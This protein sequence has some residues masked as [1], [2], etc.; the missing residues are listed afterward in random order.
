MEGGT[1][2]SNVS[3]KPTEER[4]TVPPFTC[5]ENVVRPTKSTDYDNFLALGAK[6]SIVID[7]GSHKCRAGWSTEVTPRLEFRSV[8]SKPRVK[9]A[10]ETASIVGEYDLSGGRGFDFSRSSM[11]SAFDGNVV[12]H[13]DT[14]EAIFDYIFERLGITQ[15]SVLHPVL[16][17]ECPLNPSLARAKITEMLIETYGV[18]AVAFGMDCVM[19]YTYNQAQG[20]CGPDGLLVSVGHSATHIIPMLDG[21]PQ[22][23][24]CCRLSVGGYE[25]SDF[26]LRVLR[27]RYPEHGAFFGPGIGFMRAE[28]MKEKFCFVADDYCEMLEKCTGQFRSGD[29]EGSR[30]MQLPFNPAALM[31]AAGPTEEELAR[32]KELKEKQGHRLK[33][34]AAARRESKIAERKAW[35]QKA[36]AL[37]EAEPTMSVQ[38]F[39]AGIR[40]LGFERKELLLVELTAVRQAL[41]KSK[42]SKGGDKEERKEKHEAEPVGDLLD[43]PDAQLSEDQLREKKRQRMM[44]NMW[45][46]RERARHKRE[47]ERARKA[48]EKLEEEE[49]MRVDPEGYLELLKQKLATLS[50]KVNARRKKQLGASSQGADPAG[51]LVG[52]LAGATGSGAALTSKAGRGERLG[53]AQKERMRLLATAA[54]SDNKKEDTFGANDE[55]WE[56]YKEMGNDSDS[57][58]A[59]EDE[60]ALDKVTQTLAEKCPDFVASFQA[61][62]PLLPS[63]APAAPVPV[64]PITEKDFQV[65]GAHLQVYRMA[66]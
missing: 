42:S 41:K 61:S 5:W 14:Q 58:D 45:L 47:E 11:R 54:F 38:D 27:L 22:L 35:C 49:K 25:M 56:V 51:V 8:V 50:E 24:Y 10:G 16:L 6:A 17:S 21:E 3:S 46:G 30:K 34:M 52:G 15:D 29:K 40:D 60:A 2:T 20:R 39:R 63:A 62:Q 37:L 64:E 4:E 44:R 65:G 9:S 59:R 1:G 28:E 33:E 57:D 19:G 13:H 31:R 26:L 32:K 66:S 7:S 43:V 48:K 12:Y 23:Q 55:D 18:P 36:E 53:A